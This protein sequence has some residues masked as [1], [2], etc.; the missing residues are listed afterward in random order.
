MKNIIYIQIGSNIG[1][2]YQNINKSIYLIEK[3]IGPISNCS[4]IYESS[5]WGLESQSPF[6]NCVIKIDSKLSPEETLK[7]SQMIEK[8]IG[9]VKT[10][11]WGKRIIDVDILFYNNDIIKNKN[12]IIPHPYI[13]KRKFVL[14][15]LK[16]IANDLIHPIKNKNIEELYNDCNDEGNV[17]L[18]EI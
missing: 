18:Y 9:R 6:L 5:A 11:K 10:I 4:S 14:I 12:L 8:K 17:E 3:M 7:K 16:E 15:P 13:H 2:R 1:D